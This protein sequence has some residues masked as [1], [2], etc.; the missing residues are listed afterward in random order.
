MMHNCL[1]SFRRHGLHFAFTWIALTS[2]LRGI[3][4]TAVH[5]SV[6]DAGTRSVFGD[7]QRCLMFRV[8][9]YY[10]IIRYLHSTW[11]SGVKRTNF[12][13]RTG[14]P[15][16]RSRYTEPRPAGRCGVC[17]T[18]VWVAE[19]HRQT[20]NPYALSPAKHTLYAYLPR[21]KD[22]PGCVACLLKLVVS[23]SLPGGLTPRAASFDPPPAGWGLLSRRPTL[24]LVMSEA[25]GR[26]D[27]WR[28]ANCS[29]L[30]A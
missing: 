29:N 12:I 2:E 26:E 11:S 19:D 24:V 27:A 18:H 28:A 21:S 22:P 17:N 9:Q 20:A 30:S 6:H 23:S 8:V 10:M 5:S 16:P 1:N 7:G 15:H 3:G 25:S 4:L 14:A 13:S